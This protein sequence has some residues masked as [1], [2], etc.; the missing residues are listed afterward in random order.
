[1]SIIH[2]HLY[3]IVVSQSVDLDHPLALG[4][5]MEDYLLL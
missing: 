2:G 5:L 4:F 1:V 3:I